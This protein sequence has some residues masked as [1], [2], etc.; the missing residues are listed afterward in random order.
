MSNRGA[1]EQAAAFQIGRRQPRQPPLLGQIDRFGR[2][3]LL[4]AAAGFHL[5][6]DDRAAIDRH[7]VDLPQPGAN[8]AAD[9]PIAEPPQVAGGRGLASLAQGSPPPGRGEPVEKSP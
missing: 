7:Q 8:P 1:V 6:E 5:D 3:P 9:D 4:V 2:M